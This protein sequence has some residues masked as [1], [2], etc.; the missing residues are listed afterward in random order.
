MV[1]LRWSIQFF[2]IETRNN[3]VHSRLM[4]PT[5]THLMPIIVLCMC[6]CIALNFNYLITNNQTFMCF[7][8]V[9]DSYFIPCPT[10]IGRYWTTDNNRSDGGILTILSFIFLPSIRPTLHAMRQFRT[11]GQMNKIR[12]TKI[13]KLLYVSIEN[14]VFVSGQL[15][16]SDKYPAHETYLCMK[17]REGEN[18]GQWNWCDKPTSDYAG[19]LEKGNRAIQD[20]CSEISYW[21]R[22]TNRQIKPSTWEAHPYH[23]CC[24]MGSAHSAPERITNNTQFS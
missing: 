9:R 21:H 17:C 24:S 4:K 11:N 23:N 16:F 8:L 19:W 3:S 7:G 5:C 20:N 12:I 15:L 1:D 14:R 18:R 10:N 6:V 13:N 22:I 2:C